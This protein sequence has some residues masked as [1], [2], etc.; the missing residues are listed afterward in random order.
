MIAERRAIVAIGRSRYLYDAVRHLAAVGHPVAA[1]VSDEAYD[2]YDVNAEQF[3]S[4]A[5]EVGAHFLRASSLVRERDRLAEI[6]HSGKVAAAVSANWRYKIPATV[7]DLFPSGVLNFHLGNLPDYKGNATVNWTILAGEQEIFANVHKMAPELDA[8]DVIARASITLGPDTYVGDVI[9]E[10]ERLAPQLFEQAL[11]RLVSEPNAVEV[12]GTTAGLRC[13]PRLPEDGQIDWSQ[14]VETVCRL[15]RASSKPFGGAYSY[16]DGARFTIWRAAVVPHG[17]PFMAVPGH[18]L[19]IRS[20]TGTV[21][22]ACGDGTLELEEVE[23]EGDGHRPAEMIR[24][25]RSRFRPMPQGMTQ[26]RVH[27]T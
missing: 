9:A 15:V 7:L 5:E 14:S 21:L 25:I 11:A 18:V 12:P 19:E 4:L 22:V 2:E 23:R 24:S 26:E 10:A 16:L 8:G 6:V 13:Y 27:I 20:D 3:Q 17:Q 1:I